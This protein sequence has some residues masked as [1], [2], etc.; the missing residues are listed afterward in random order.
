MVTVNDEVTLKIVSYNMHGFHQGYAVLEDL[1]KT[2]YPDVFLLQEHWLTPGNLFNFDRYFK[3]YFTFGCSAMAKSVESGMLRGRPFG[4][5]MMLIKNN[6]RKH[7]E[8]V[9]CDDRYIIVRIGNLLIINVYLPCCGTDGRVDT[10]KEILIE[11]ESWCRHFHWCRCIIAGDLNCNLDSNDTVAQLIV[12]LCDDC[13]LLRCDKLFQSDMHYT[14][15]NT[16][17]NQYSYIDYALVSSEV[18]LSDFVVMEPSVNFSDH[19]PLFISLVCTLKSDCSKGERTAPVQYYPRWDKADRDAYYRY[20]GDNLVSLV[21]EL[22][23]LIINNSCSTDEIDEVYERIVSVLIN[24]EKLH[25]PRRCKNFYKF[26]WSEELTILKQDAVETDRAWK[27]ARRP[28][29]GPIF[30]KRQRSRLKYRKC[31]RECQN[32]STLVYTNDLHDALLRKNGVEFWKCWR[33]NFQSVNNCVEVENSVDSDIIVD[34]FASHFS[35]TYTHNNA[36][37]A[38]EL[39]DEYKC[40]RATYSGFPITDEHVI[41]TELVSNVIFRLRSGKAADIT[42]LTA[43]HLTH[44]HPSLSLVLCRLFKLIVQHEYVPSG[45]RHS[46]IVPVPKIKDCRAKSMTCHDFRGIAVSPII[47]KVFEYCIL[48]KFNKFL[49]SCDVQFGFKKG[50]GCRN[51]IYTVRKTVDRFVDGGSTVNICSIDL[52]K[53]FDKVNHSALYIKLMKRNI[54]VELLGLLENWLSS[55]FAC[56]KWHCSWS[57]AFKVS[58]SV[59][60]GSVLSPC[61]F[62]VCWRRI[63]CNETTVA[64]RVEPLVGGGSLV[65]PTGQRLRVD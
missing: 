41:D 25:V 31:I 34:K 50:L 43:E 16:S 6:L 59:R 38:K 57:F 15:V 33:A 28:R 62:A 44:C 26:W 39:Y 45:F 1:S 10:C 4:G 55:C 18:V 29:F 56:V 11:I 23:E 17:L 61:V 47:S 32:R 19:L 30:D 3:E 2:Q 46:Y 53:A 58:S 13:S 51:A 54:P 8:T 48:E 24:G 20:T 60:Q 36:A 27:A 7:T 63:S 21:S 42:G 14:Y 37:K 35:S 12:S 40:M 65:G 52:N 49:T 9:K 22:D 64:I 5:V